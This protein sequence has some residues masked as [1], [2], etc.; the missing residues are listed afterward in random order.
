MKMRTLV[1]MIGLGASTLATAVAVN[2]SFPL[3]VFAV[4][5]KVVLEPANAE[6]QRIQIWGTF[7]LWDETSGHGFRPATRGFLYYS[8][9]KEQLGICRNEW[10]DLKSVAGTG[11]VIG[12]GSRSLAAG[13]VR[14]ASEQASAPQTYPIQFGVVRMGSS[15]RGDVFDQLKALAR[16]R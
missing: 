2:A 5:D 14:P 8:C 10:T 15:P 7:A 9:S 12:F 1:A 6:P 13:R 11:Q 3:G 16:A 4:V